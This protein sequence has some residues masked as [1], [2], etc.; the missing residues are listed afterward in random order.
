MPTIPT[1]CAEKLKGAW[2]NSLG[3]ICCESW[4]TIL[5]RQQDCI[6]LLLCEGTPNSRLICLPPQVQR[7]HVAQ[8]QARCG[9]RRAFANPVQI[10]Q[11]MESMAGRAFLGRV[12]QNAALVHVQAP[13]NP[14]E[15]RILWQGAGFEVIVKKTLRLSVYK[16]E[17]WQTKMCRVMVLALPSFL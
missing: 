10:S 7:R 3:L 8:Q 17:F 9:A 6:R 1:P 15:G 2:Y 16:S 11:G 14:P 13:F 12:S 4:V 5:R